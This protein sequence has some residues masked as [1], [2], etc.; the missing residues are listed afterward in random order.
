MEKIS[1]S[2]N[3]EVVTFYWSDDGRSAVSVMSD[4]NELKRSCRIFNA[5]TATAFILLRVSYDGE[6]ATPQIK[7]RQATKRNLAS[8]GDNYSQRTD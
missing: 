6:L 2:S 3:S 7:F 1:K 8:L 4:A 5:V